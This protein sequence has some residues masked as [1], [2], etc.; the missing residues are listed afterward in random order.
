MS[1]TLAL[2][3]ASTSPLAAHV[4]DDQIVVIA[5]KLKNLRGQEVAQ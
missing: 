4:S 5:R 1:A 2:M 3:M